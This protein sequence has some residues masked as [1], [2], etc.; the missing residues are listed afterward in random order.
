MRGEA[1]RGGVGKGVTGVCMCVCVSVQFFLNICSLFNLAIFRAHRHTHTSHIHTYVRRVYAHLIPAQPH[2]HTH[3][4]AGRTY[5]ATVWHMH[6]LPLYLPLF[7]AHLPSSHS[8]FSLLLPL[9]PQFP[10][11][12]HAPRRSTWRNK[13]SCTKVCNTFYQQSFKIFDGAEKR[14]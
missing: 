5:A 13:S 11:T 4:R 3:T 6:F 10:F 8:S 12:C 9:F 7:S 14:N 2:T 1:G